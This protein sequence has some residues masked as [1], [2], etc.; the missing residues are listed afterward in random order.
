MK[1]VLHTC[2]ISWESFTIFV[3]F[4]KHVDI[5]GT[6]ESDSSGSESEESDRGTDETNPSSTDETDDDEAVTRAN[7]SFISASGEVW[8][9]TPPP[10]QGRARSSNILRSRQGVTSYATQRIDEDASSAFKVIFGRELLD[11]IVFETN[12]EGQ[13]IKGAEW[14][15]L[16]NTELE[17][18]IGLC[19]LRGVYKSK[20]ESLR[21][22]WHPVRG[23]QIFSMTM[24]I[25]RFEEIRRF[26]HFDNRETRNARQQRD[27]L[28]AVRLLLDGVVQNSQACYR[29][30]A[31]VTADEQLYPFRGRC[32]FIQ[33]MPSK[34]AKYGLKF[35]ILC[36]A[37][38][39]YCSHIIL[40]TGKDDSRGDTSLGEHVV[41][42]LSGHLFGTGRNI[43][44]DNFFTS[45]SL[46]RSVSAK[47]LNLVGTVRGNRREVPPALRTVKGREL[48]SSVFCYTTDDVQLVSYQAK[49]G[50]NV[51]LM[52][53]QHCQPTVADTPPHKPDVILYYNATKVGVDC[54]DERVGTY[55]VKY[56][57]RRWHV[58]V[59]CNLIDIAAFNAFVLYCDIFPD[60]QKAVR[61][62]RRLFL[63]DLGMSLSEK[64]RRERNSPSITPAPT[65]SSV[66]RGRCD[67]CPRTADR[68]SKTKCCQ[69]NKFVCSDHC[70]N[71]C[72]NC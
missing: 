50:K 72:L 16:S 60:Y 48:N 17:A 53:S 36:D 34:P 59:F 52:S 23:R 30:G 14:K 35:W 19:I 66:L 7:P 44:C 5:L 69:C 24:T 2:K 71:T 62:R 63:T 9:Q 22:L 6:F 1:T 39:Y 25:T 43:T 54:L 68:K 51:L 11:T 8:T 47:D 46:A 31:C 32:S 40:Y 65:S 56:K 64:H 49:K 38:T 45:L 20:G 57:T 42:S 26:L 4:R 28:A 58:V 13:R 10:R 41:M 29:H 27:K 12:R 33:F 55:S 18:Y 21:D 37:E 61:H 67:L 15:P 70:K 3:I